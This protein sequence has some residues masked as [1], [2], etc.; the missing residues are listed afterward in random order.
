MTTPTRHCSTR[1]PVNLIGFGDFVFFGAFVL[2]R[3]MAA[4][5]PQR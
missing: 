4:R 5:R 1:A 2:N 3:D